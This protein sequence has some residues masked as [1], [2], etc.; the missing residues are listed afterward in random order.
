M[1]KSWFESHLTSLLVDRTDT[2]DSWR[3]Q[4]PA[5]SG[6]TKNFENW[7][8]VELVDR[9]IRSGKIRAVRTN[10]HFSDAKI[11]ASEVNGLSGRK[12]EAV[13]LSP[14]ISIRLKKDDCIVSLEIKTGLAPKEIFN[15]IKIVKLTRRRESAIKPS[16]YGWYYYQTGLRKLLRG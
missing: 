6:R 15:D 16:L 2:L 7:L 13:H 9:V 5:L 3:R 11:K 1:K 8:L 12:S 4:I 10:G 14:D